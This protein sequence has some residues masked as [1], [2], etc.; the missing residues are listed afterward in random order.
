VVTEAGSSPDTID[1]LNSSNW[2]IWLDFQDLETIWS[3]DEATTLITAGEEVVVRAVTNKSAGAEAGY[4]SALASPYNIASADTFAPVYDDSVEA[5][6]FAKIS[7]TSGKTL[8]FGSGVCTA[9]HPVDTGGM[10]YDDE[11]GGWTCISVARQPTQQTEVNHVLWGNGSNIDGVYIGHYHSEAAETGNH[12]IVTDGAGGSHDLDVPT[13]APQQ[14]GWAGE[15]SIYWFEIGSD[16]DTTAY[17][18]S[19]TPTSSDEWNSETGNCTAEF[20]TTEAN[21]ILQTFRVGAH[22]VSGGADT[23][24]G[25]WGGHIG[26][27]LAFSTILDATDRQ[28]LWDHLAAKWGVTF[29]PGT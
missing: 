12:F 19:S 11:V 7:T 22:D 3:D 27:Q 9:S 6:D 13:P 2:H 1:E 8:Q 23:P 29:N 10:L 17:F 14:L 26:E 15:W 28:A 18:G 25:S 21:S 16:G 4:N 5:L 24:V 20:P